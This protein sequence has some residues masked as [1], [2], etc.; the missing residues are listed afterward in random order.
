MSKT[1]QRT[2]VDQLRNIRGARALS[3]RN[4]VLGHARATSSTNSD[5][6]LL[7]G[8]LPSTRRPYRNCHHLP[9]RRFRHHVARALKYCA[10]F[11]QQTSR[12]H[13]AAYHALL[14]NLHA[15]ER[16]NDPLEFSA[17][18][19]HSRLELALHVRLIAQ[20]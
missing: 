4:L 3:K 12:V 10:G 15:L 7:S 18:N 19:Y 6:K 13:L 9:V 1:R 11:D 14:M 2:N 20:D 17:D 8:W 16:A 5:R